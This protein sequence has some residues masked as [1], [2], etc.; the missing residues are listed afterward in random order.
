[1]MSNGGCAVVWGMG[2]SR[3]RTRWNCCLIDRYV[4]LIHCT[5]CVSIHLPGKCHWSCL[6]GICFGLIQFVRKPVREILPLIYCTLTKF[7]CQQDLSG[8]HYFIEA[9]GLG[10]DH[11]S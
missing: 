9:P 11:R 2:G 1:M 7:A 4:W 6:S 8:G 3:W 5:L 10:V